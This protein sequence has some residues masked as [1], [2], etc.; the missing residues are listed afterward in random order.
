VCPVLIFGGTSTPP[1]GTQFW[2]SHTKPVP[3]R[4]VRERCGRG[5]HGRC[6]ISFAATSVAVLI[7]G[8]LAFRHA[9]EEEVATGA[10]GV[11]PSGGS[12]SAS[13]APIFATLREKEPQAGRSGAP[14]DPLQPTVPLASPL[15]VLA[16][17]QTAAPTHLSIDS[18]SANHGILAERPVDTQAAPRE[19]RRT[20]NVETA[21]ELRRAIEYEMCD[22]IQLAPAPGAD[23]DEEVSERAK[24]LKRV[25]KV[26]GACNL[27]L[28]PILPHHDFQSDSA[29]TEATGI[30]GGSSNDEVEAGAYTLFS[31]I[32]VDRP[33][34]IQGDALTL[35]L[36]DCK[37]SVRAF[38]VK[39]RTSVCSETTAEC[40]SCLFVNEPLAH[41]YLNTLVGA[42][43]V[44]DGAVT[45]RVVASPCGLCVST[46]G[47]ER[48]VLVRP[49]EPTTT[50]ENGSRF[51]VALSCLSPQQKAGISSVCTSSQRRARRPRSKNRS[52][53]RLGPLRYVP[54]VA[55]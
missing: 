36:I 51:G 30:L 53:Y 29:D 3:P 6:W 26:R 38:R 22:F 45:R 4:K 27:S 49:M 1:V 21:A 17:S 18:A 20:C 5:R 7:A 47:G 33:I 14:L 40:H 23:E 54:S 25:T 37:E 52:T 42:T 19:D 50:R 48:F 15:D 31:E 46:K 10:A 35:P 16:T 24:C 44:I 55:A 34:T 8:W 43:S 32:V 28:S 39:V 2:T 12:S 41:P 9:A 13:V 11:S